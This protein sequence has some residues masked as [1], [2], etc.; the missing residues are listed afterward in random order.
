M[1][2]IIQAGSINTTALSVPDLY[3]QIV[4]PALLSLNG[5]P[6]NVLGVVGTA[7]W[8]PVNRPVVLG[9]YADLL[10]AF[11]TPTPRKFDLGTQVA[12][13]CA[14]GASSFVGVRVTDGTDTAASY[15]MLYSSTSAS[16]PVLITALYTGSLGNAIGLA[17]QAGS[18]AGTWRLVLS[19][20][21]TLPEVFDNI[22]ASGA[23]ASFWANL[24]TAVNAG[25]GPLRGPSQL[26]VASLGSGTGAPPIAIAGQALLNGSDGA[27]GVTA[28]SMIGIDGTERTGL[29][30]LRGQSCAIALLAD[31]DDDGTWSPQVAFGLSEGVYMILTGPAGDTITNA[32]TSKQAAGVDSY[33]GKLMLGDWLSWYD[34]A[35][36]QTRLVSPQGFIAGR[37]ANLSPE[38]SSLNKPIYGIIASQRSGAA[39]SGQS[40]TYSTAELSTLFEA[41]IDVIC[42]PAP[43]GAFWSARSGHNSSSNAA[44]STDSYTRL[45]NYIASTLASAMGT[46]VGQ[47]ITAT[48][49]AN[50][51]ATLLGYLGNLLG[52]GVLG[53]TTGSAPYAVQCDTSNNPISRT[54]LGYVQADIQV[55][56]QGINE[57]F[58]VNLQGG[59]TVQ[60][61]T[62]SGS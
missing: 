4:A 58:L 54:S 38:Q 25:T 7:T 31:S 27:A 57:K 43:G 32:I 35:N 56:Y 41:G 16:Y 39:G 21:G 48:L 24:V 42:T 37:L 50:I 59:S 20:P 29:Y 17:L 2:Q 55:Q 1:A 26:V 13:A 22:D 19:L 60:V 36:Q 11:G 9:G 46:Y 61:S 51:R 23:P 28:Q 52:Q 33:A 40:S 47:L 18:R 30:A 53:S 62:S 49:F 10:T 3:V 15:A 45:T 34:Q 8:G 6:S 14:Q 12:T 44:V 5:V